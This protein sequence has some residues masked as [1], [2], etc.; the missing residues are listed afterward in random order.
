MLGR[1]HATSLVHCF[2]VFSGLMQPL[3]NWITDLGKCVWRWCMW[4]EMQVCTLQCLHYYRDV[5]ALRSQKWTS[6]WRFAAFVRN[7]PYING[8][9]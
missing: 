2:G 6:C 7:T 3:I 5:T 8:L 9:T 1:S 4:S